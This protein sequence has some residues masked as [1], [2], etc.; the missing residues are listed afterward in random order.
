MILFPKKEGGKFLVYLRLRSVQKA[1][2][3]IMTATATAAMM[4]NSVVIRG[5]SVGSGSI[6]CA[7]DAAGPTPIAVSAYELQ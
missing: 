4:A 1:T 3:P 7:A 5:A 6:G 2:M